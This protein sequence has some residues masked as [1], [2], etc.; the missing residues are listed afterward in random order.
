[1]FIFRGEFELVSSKSWHTWFNAAISKGIKEHSNHGEFSA[2]EK[3]LHSL[4]LKKDASSYGVIQ[5]LRKH[6][7]DLL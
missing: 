6:N 1:M 4:I 5:Y 7:F 3:V 2:L